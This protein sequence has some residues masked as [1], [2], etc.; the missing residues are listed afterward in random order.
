M[1]V[2]HNGDFNTLLRDILAVAGICGIGWSVYLI[3]PSFT[4]G[5]IGSI[6]LAA[7]IAAHL[8]TKRHK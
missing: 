6:L 2:P 1:R 7:V 4:P 8:T 3:A 5:I